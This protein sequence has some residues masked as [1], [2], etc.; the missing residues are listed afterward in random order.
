MGRTLNQLAS[1]AAVL[2]PKATEG[3]F[4]VYA[5]DVLRDFVHEVGNVYSER[6]E[7]TITPST[8]EY[9]L[10]A[11]F[12]RF[13]K[14]GVYLRYS[15]RTISTVVRSSNVVTVTTATT[16]LLATGVYVRIS[17]V[18]DDTFDDDEVQVTV[19][20]TTTFTYA[21]TGSDGSSSG[22]YVK[23]VYDWD[24]ARWLEG[25]EEEEITANADW[26]T[27]TGRPS[28]YCV[29]DGLNITLSLIPDGYD[30]TLIADY[31]AELPATFAVTDGLPL[32]SWTDEFLRSGMIAR[33]A[34]VAGDVDRAALEEARYQNGINRWRAASV[35][36]MQ[37][38]SGDPYGADNHPTT[39]FRRD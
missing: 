12:R 5:D 31:D 3:Q 15:D 39:D 14:Q 28:K 11:D 38:A 34:R 36:R 24:E 4:L 10:P 6:W 7:Q 29:R 9:A 37:T 25:V 32:P 16:H 27:T 30:P 22:G 2:Y 23:W 20:G 21:N 35:D 13:R 8:A 18:T 33:A 26:R 1:Q 19:T 17:G